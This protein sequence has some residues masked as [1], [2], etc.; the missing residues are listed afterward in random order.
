MD[1]SVR[2]VVESDKGWVLEMVRRWGGDYI[3]S[4]R[5][6]IYPSEIEGFIAADETGERVGL[7]TYEITGDQCEIVTLHAFTKYFGIGTRLLQAVIDRLKGSEVRRLWLITT[8]DNLDAIR[9]YQ[10]RGFTIAAIHVNALEKSRELKPS[11]PFIG[12]YGI[13]I[14]DEIEFEMLLR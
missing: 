10:K 2:P 7:V 3:V 11:I 8:N 4:R 9:F 6:K 14:R 1:I 12:N 13:P 5:R